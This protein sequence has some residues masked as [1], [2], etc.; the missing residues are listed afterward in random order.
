MKIGSGCVV[1]ITGAGGGIGKAHAL[2]FGR[3]GARVV[4]NDLGGSVA[5]SG[6]SDMADQVADE[7]KSGGGEAIASVPAQF[8]YQFLRVWEY[9]WNL[10]RRRLKSCL[11]PL[12]FVGALD[13]LLSISP[14]C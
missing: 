11:L 1:V 2:E 6:Q 12:H 8:R 3:R 10:I 4:V 9:R 14:N 7:I 13:R 5:G